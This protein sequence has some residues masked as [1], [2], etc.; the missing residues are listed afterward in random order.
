[1]KK[2]L[3][4]FG[5]GLAALFCG[6]SILSLGSPSDAELPSSSP[7]TISTNCDFPEELRSVNHWNWSLVV[8]DEKLRATIWYAPGSDVITVS[9]RERADVTGE[10]DATEFEFTA[11]FPIADVAWREGG[12]ELYVAGVKK[13]GPGTCASVIEK[14][15]L[16]LPRGSVFWRVGSEFERGQPSSANLSDYADVGFVGGVYA[17]PGKRSYSVPRVKKSTLITLGAG[18]TISSLEVDP[19][20]RFI[21]YR[22]NE[23]GNVYTVN[24]IDGGGATSLELDSAV[25]PAL[26]STTGEFYAWQHG[27]YGR[28]Y[29]LETGRKFF[30]SKDGTLARVFLFD[31]DNDG[32]FEAHLE[33]DYSTYYSSS[34]ADRGLQSSIYDS[35]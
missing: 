20:G 31:L 26:A 7:A 24:G 8:K 19:E 25:A 32:H 30:G 1:M 29:E 6:Q 10:W 21:A 28:V 27:E 33:A 11:G 13:V 34:L 5:L 14:W 22:V 17:P 35:E 3:A 18:Q 16:D 4:L 15:I 9:R 23:S 2:T 12:E